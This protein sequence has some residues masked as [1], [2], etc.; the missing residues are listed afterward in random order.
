M[1]GPRPRRRMA[2][3]IRSDAP[4]LY[5]T[6]AARNPRVFP[7]LAQRD[8]V[9]DNDLRQGKNSSAPNTLHRYHRDN[10]EHVSDRCF[11][12]FTGKTDYMASKRMDHSPRP[13]MSMFIDCAAPQMAAPPAKRPIEPSIIG[14]RPN[15]LD[16]PPAGGIEAAP[17]R[18]YALPTHT[19]SLDLRAWTIVG[20]AVPTEVNS[21]AERKTATLVP[22]AHKVQR[23]S[24]RAH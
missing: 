14:W 9:C 6:Y 1:L 5:R 16:K 10:Y 15:I 8:H 3:R 24:G 12:E 13:A 4:K 2:F 21:R 17:A 19:N 7:S 11:D 18:A 22:T 23:E 20:S